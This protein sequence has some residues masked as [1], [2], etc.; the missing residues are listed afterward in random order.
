MFIDSCFFTAGFENKETK[1]RTKVT[2][3]K[4]REHRK[5]SI[6]WHLLFTFRYSWVCVYVYYYYG[7]SSPVPTATIM[8]QH[9]FFTFP[10]Q[11]SYVF[12]YTAS[13]FVLDIP[14]ICSFFLHF[15]FFFMNMHMHTHNKCAPTNVMSN[16]NHELNKKTSRESEEWER[17]AERKWNDCM[18]I[19]IMKQRTPQTMTTKR[20]NNF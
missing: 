11:F 17:R 5:I 8:L 3:T 12:V 19:I 14:P 13:F 6:E 1:T 2:V 18:K 15:C 16:K 9:H 7:Y 20:A 10:N 4:H